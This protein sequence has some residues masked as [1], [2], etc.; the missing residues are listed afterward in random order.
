MYS[1]GSHGPTPALISDVLPL[2]KAHGAH[3]VCGHDHMLEHISHAGVEHILTGAG[4]NC[5]YKQEASLLLP[6]G[7]LKFITSDKAKSAIEGGFVSFSLDDETTV[8]YYD[9]DGKVIYTTPGIAPR[10]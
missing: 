3:Y 8:T 9:Q 7:S 2:L 1:A 10:A 6:L 5:C 4:D